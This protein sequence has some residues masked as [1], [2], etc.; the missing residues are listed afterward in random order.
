MTGLRREAVTRA[1][2]PTAAPGGPCN[3]DRRGVRPPPLSPLMRALDSSGSGEISADAI[4]KS[5][6]LLKDFVNFGSD[7]WRPPQRADGDRKGTSRPSSRPADDQ[8]GSGDD[9]QGPNNGQASDGG[10]HGPDSDGGHGPSGHARPPLPADALIF[11]ALDTDCNGVLSV[12]EIKNA[13]TSLKRLDKNGDGKISRQELLLLPPR[14]GPGGGGPGAGGPGAGEPGGGDN[15]DSGRDSGKMGP[16]G[17]QGPP[18]PPPDE[19]E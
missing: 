1:G 16:G 7:S 10:R 13:P 4:T 12:D 8:K 11:W 5:A 6:D 14:H 2:H 18:P 19:G 15:G 3:G 9:R 17:R